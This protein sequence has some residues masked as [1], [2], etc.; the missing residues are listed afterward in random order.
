[1]SCELRRTHHDT[2]FSPV[3]KPQ[4]PLGVSPSIK[5]MVL[6]EG[7]RLRRAGWFCS[8]SA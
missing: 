3:E 2:F 7:I 5:F 1:M 8:V 4:L 6:S